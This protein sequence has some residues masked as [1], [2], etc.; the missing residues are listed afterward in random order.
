MKKPFDKYWYYHASVQDPDETLGFIANTYRRQ[1]TKRAL[2]L[3]E[4]FCGTFA[5]SAEW[6][7]RDGTRRAVGVD[8]DPKPIKYGMTH[9]FS[10]LT[11]DEQKRIQ[12][13][14][15]NVLDGGLPKVDALAAM[16]FSYFVF[17]QRKQ[18]LA[19]L[20][21]CHRRLNKKGIL[22]LD[23]FGGTSTMEPNEDESRLRGFTYFWDQATFD[24]VT[25]HSMFYIHYKRKG[26][27][28][29]EKVF[30][31]DWRMW[32]IPELTECLEEAGFTESQ[33]W[34][35]DTDK[36]GHGTGTFSLTKG[37]KNCPAWVS[38]VVGVKR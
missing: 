25:H 22:V 6:V 36:R 38:Y 27:R 23:T 4:D 18:L 9:Y 29:R 5:L 17:K 12:I 24:P 14:N 8:L 1:F 11:P 34:W 7:K 28:K 19:Y 16:N 30:R 15:A 31:Y 35:E 21:N 3:G 13:I 37:E 32:S 33:V 26:E 10:A 20:K 2:T